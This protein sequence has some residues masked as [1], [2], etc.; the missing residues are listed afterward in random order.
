MTNTMKHTIQ[1]F[2]LAIALASSAV[3]SAPLQAQTVYAEDMATSPAVQVLRRTEKL[4][5][6]T[7]D[8]TFY[9]PSRDQLVVYA[10]RLKQQLIAQI[11]ELQQWQKSPVKPAKDSTKDSLEASSEASSQVY[12]LLKVLKTACTESQG[13]LNPLDVPLREAWGFTPSSLSYGVPETSVLQRWSQQLRQQ[14]CEAIVPGQP[15]TLDYFAAGWLIDQS[16][17]LL[18]SPGIVAAKL[19]IDNVAY[20]AGVPPQAKAWKV[21]VYH[22]RKADQLIQYF[23]LKDQSLVLLGDAD[24]HFYANGLRYPDFLDSRTGKVHSE[25]AGA[26]V[27]SA[28]ALDA[29]LLARSVVL[30][31]QE[32]AKARVQ[33]SSPGT[34][35]IRWQEQLEQ[36]TPQEFHS[37]GLPR[38]PIRP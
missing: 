19:H 28:S 3:M 38:G 29:Q 20:Y 16:K 5:L 12:P 6:Y 4:G 34:R 7:I 25:S 31:T 15:L 21:P 10:D 8:I 17:S 22:P 26:Y 33:N 9:G 14:G 35:V 36:L 30:L 27:L 32:E 23:Y 24:T 2:I 37:D 1:S 11:A 13:A 18:A